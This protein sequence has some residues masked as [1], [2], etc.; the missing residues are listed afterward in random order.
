MR[1]ET[2]MLPPRE[3]NPNWHGHWAQKARATA[4]YQKAVY[5]SALEHFVS[6]ELRFKKAEVK[7]TFVIRDK[8]G[9]KDA[10]NALAC[11]KPAIDA[12]VLAGVIP[13]DSDE[14]LQYRMP[15]MYQVD[16]ERAPLTILE[17]KEVSILQA[18]SL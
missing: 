16:K 3:L 12:C 9:Y 5:Y 11:L 14:Y 7:V 2:P 1:I 10:D 17:F 13:D 18:K 8:R 6:P 15:I 4:N